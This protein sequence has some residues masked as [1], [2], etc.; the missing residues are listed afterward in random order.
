MT[1]EA[2]A[3][4]IV[5]APLAY[6]RSLADAR[7]APLPPILKRVRSKKELIHTILRGPRKT[8]TAAAFENAPPQAIDFSVLC[9]F[10]QIDEPGTHKIFSP[11][12]GRGFRWRGMQ[13]RMLRNMDRFLKTAQKNGATV[14]EV[15]VMEKTITYMIDDLIELV[16]CVPLYYVFAGRR[17]VRSGF[18]RHESTED[19]HTDRSTLR[20]RVI[21]TFSGPSTKYARDKDGTDTDR[22]AD[23]STTMHTVTGGFFKKSVGAYHRAP[24]AP[25]STNR[26]AV[27][28]W[29][30]Y[31]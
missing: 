1:A 21:R 6:T 28:L 29:V 18:R 20:G 26:F 16:R 7:S 8:P 31:I 3:R 30:S 24:F 9:R 5:G 25:G 11:L 19:W 2:L 4:E 10:S 22:P 14:A 15:S 23:A 17:P 27:A 13:R 12:R